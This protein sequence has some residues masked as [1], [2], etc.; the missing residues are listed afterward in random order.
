MKINFVTETG[1][2]ILGRWCDKWSKLIPESTISNTYILDRANV[3]V[4]YATFETKTNLDI[5]YFTHRE[6]HD[7][8][9]QDKFDETA[10]QMDWCF[11][12]CENTLK[13]LPKGKSSI[14][15]PGITI[16]HVKRDVVIGVASKVQPWNRKRM[17][18]AESLGDIEG[19]EI[20]IAGG[21]IPHDLMGEWYS[22]LDCV[23]ITSENEGGPMSA[24]EA[25]AC[26]RPLIAPRN[27]GWCDKF[28]ALRFDTYD[29][30]R[31][32]VESLVYDSDSM[33]SSGAQQIVD[34]VNGLTNV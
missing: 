14:L 19:I 33:W 28:P 9:L 21:D 16:P 23:L 4:N 1:R 8:A 15:E 25:I 6:L 26:H 29:E 31:G 13:L 11:A 2:W 3:Y 22:N 18:W 5:G 34:K 27:V 7:K 12:Q 30:L 10:E 24:P 32:I 17:E 20:R